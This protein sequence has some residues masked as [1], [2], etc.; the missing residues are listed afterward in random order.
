MLK[1]WLQKIRENGPLT[2]VLAVAAAVFVILAAYAFASDFRELACNRLQDD[3]YYYLQPAWNFPR[4]G[5]FTFDGEH[6]TY[7]FQPLWMLL[8][9]FLSIFSPDKIIFLR[10]SVALGGLFY[11]LTAVALFFLLRRWL[12]GWRAVIGPVLWVANPGLAGIFITGKENA[13]YAFLLVLSCWMILRK[14]AATARGALPLGIVLGLTVLARVNALVPVLL[15]LMVFFWLGEGARAQR[16]RRTL[17]VL[18]GMLA[19]LL[20]WCVYAQL[21][22]GAVFPNSGSAKLVDSFAALAVLAQRVLP[23]FSPDWIRSLVPVSQQAFLARPDLLALPTTALVASYVT[24][25]LPGL[26]FGSWAGLFAFLG[27]LD[28][29]LKLVLLAAGGLAALAAC[30]LEWRWSAR[31]R[32][33]CA[34]IALA[35]FLSAAL[36][37]LSNWALMPAYLYWGVWYAVPEMLALILALALVIGMPLQWIASGP[38][39]AAVRWGV[40][41]VGVGLTVAGLVQVA[42]SWQPRDSSV[43]LEA[44]QQQKYQA[45]VWMNE[46]LPRD[47]RAASFS[48]GLLGYFFDTGRVVNIDGL[49]NTPQFISDELIGHL[50][51]VRDLASIDPIRDYLRTEQIG[52]LV[53]VEPVERIQR[54]EYLGLVDPGGGILLYR[55]DRPINWGPGEPE[56]RMIVVEI[57][58]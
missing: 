20:P 52:Y 14:R 27:T 13:L 3:S 48:A 42:R 40:A 55:G 45:A 49:A 32:R 10:A 47:T 24:G 11:C 33:T 18:A 2:F 43:A 58:Q 9:S 44:T 4:L 53:N 31:E 8:L 34:A 5:F 7:G 1:G 30:L 15:L 21:S 36:N 57:T 28:Y 25:F 35:L 54:G 56:Q 17:A 50:L 51:Y 38:R 12:G 41:A 46:N 26:A 37:T 29:R 16:A 19:I 23:S 39:I 22:F 6:P